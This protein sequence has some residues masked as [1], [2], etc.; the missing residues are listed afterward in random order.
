M[1]FKI[2]AFH[3]KI[4]EA[5]HRQYVTVLWHSNKRLKMD[6]IVHLLPLGDY[7]ESYQAKGKAVSISFRLTIMNFTGGKNHSLMLNVTVLH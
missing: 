2:I 5:I 1:I 3:K 6:Q 4:A 7:K